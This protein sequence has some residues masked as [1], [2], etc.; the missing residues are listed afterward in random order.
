MSKVDLL[1]TL[2]PTLRIQCDWTKKIDTDATATNDLYTK[3]ILPPTKLMFQN[4]PTTCATYRQCNRRFLIAIAQPYLVE[5]CTEVAQGFNLAI[6]N[7][8]LRS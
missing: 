4:P 2:L 1:N 5:W 8:S 7:Q 6:F 3:D